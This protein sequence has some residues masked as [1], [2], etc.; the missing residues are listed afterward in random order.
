MRVAQQL[1]QAAAVDIGVGEVGIE[2]DGRGIVL[3][4]FFDLTQ[5]RGC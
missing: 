2:L 1:A 3:C 5:L 4:G